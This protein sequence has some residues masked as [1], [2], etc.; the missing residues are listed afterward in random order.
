MIIGYQSRYFPG[1]V[2]LM[3]DVHELNGVA[4][5]HIIF[6]MAENVFSCLN[7]TVIFNGIDF[8]LLLTSQAQLRPVFRMIGHFLPLRQ[9]HSFSFIHLTR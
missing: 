8:Q 4:L 7:S 1:S 3:P 5:H 9:Y 2:M 6:R